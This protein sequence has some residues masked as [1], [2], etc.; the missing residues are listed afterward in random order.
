MNSVNIKF[1]HAHIQAHL[2][3]YGIFRFNIGYLS[4]T[5]KTQIIAQSVVYQNITANLS[6]KSVLENTI[7]IIKNANNHTVKPIA[8]HKASLFINFESNSFIII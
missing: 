6:I 3:Q 2:N 5:Q 8:F 1:I 7:G 4:K